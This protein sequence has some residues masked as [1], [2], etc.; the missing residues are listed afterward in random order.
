[1]S[2]VCFFNEASFITDLCN[3]VDLRNTKFS[4]CL[5]QIQTESPD[6]SDYKCLKGVDFN[7]KVPTD[8]IDKFSKN[9]ACTKQIFEDF[10][11]K[12]ALENFDEYAEMTAEKYE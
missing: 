7:S 11:G 8:I 3:S 5:S 12:E 4:E 10:C 2:P 1:M 9:K 6:L